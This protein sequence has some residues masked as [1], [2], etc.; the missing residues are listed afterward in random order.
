MKAMVLAAGFGLRMRPLTNLMAKPALPVLNRPLIAWVLDHLARHRVTD[1][2]I[3]LHHRPASVRRAV[4][5]GR[6]FGVRV[7][8]SRERRLLGTGGGPRRVRRFF[9]DEPFLLV[10][11]D[12]VLGLDLTALV[13]RHRASGARATLAL[14]PNPDPRRY[15]PIVTDARGRIV[16]LPGVARRR[17]GRASLFTGVH[18]LD[19]ALLERAPAG[20]SDSVRDLYAPLVAAGERLLGVRAR[21]AW[22]DLGTPKGY[23]EAQLAM[24][25]SGFAGRRRRS[26]VARTARA[27]QG[28]RIV[29]SVVGPG[30]EVGAGAVVVESILWPGVRVGARAHVRRCIVAG[31]GRVA[32]GADVRSA[33]VAAG[34]RTPLR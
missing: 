11:G 19:P 3:N 14:R 34:T 18:V 32:A 4:G 5:D 12:A 29:R 8:Y 13:A 9:G 24:L 1:V 6:R 27:G 10:N 17:A 2:V 31:R 7:R 20:A 26:L 21:G 30:V 15:P 23:L 25:A 22:F 33:V 16:W 28:A